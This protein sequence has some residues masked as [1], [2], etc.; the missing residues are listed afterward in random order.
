MIHNLDLD[1]LARDDG[2][3]GR[4]RRAGAV[5]APTDVVSVMV[6]TE[7]PE[8]SAQAC[9]WVLNRGDGGRCWQFTRVFVGVEVN[10]TLASL[11]LF[12]E[13]FAR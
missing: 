13:R 2:D 8:S 12:F 4:G 7:S 5:A 3:A 10:T 11:T 9:E 6:Q 1:N